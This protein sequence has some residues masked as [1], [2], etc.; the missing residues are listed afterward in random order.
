M[1]R[2]STDQLLFALAYQ[3]PPCLMGLTLK[4][5]I[6][7]PALRMVFVLPGTLVHEALHLIVGLLLNGK[8]LSMSLWPRKVG[9]RQWVLGSV[10]FKNLRWYKRHVHRI[11]ATTGNSR[12]HALQSNPQ[13]VVAHNHGSRAMGNYYANTGHVPP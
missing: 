4:W 8:P 11:G 12:C 1:I 7:I 10:G 3:I 9:A 2:V 5:L 13:R 6:P